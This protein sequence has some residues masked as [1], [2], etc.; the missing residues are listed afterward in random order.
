MKGYYSSSAS[1]SIGSPNLNFRNDCVSPINSPN[2]SILMRYLRSGSPSDHD[3]SPSRN[4]SRPIVS[5]SSISSRSPLSGVE[6]LEEDVL[7]MDG[8]LVD[9]NKISKSA[10]KF[11][12][13][14][15]SDSSPNSG[16]NLYKTELCMSWEDTGT[17]RYG[18]KC[19]FAHGQEEMRPLQNRFRTDYVVQFMDPY[20]SPLSSPFSS[21]SKKISPETTAPAPTKEARKSKSKKASLTQ[22]NDTRS[23]TPN[24][25]STD[26]S[27][28]DDGIV[29][30]LPSS[31]GKAPSRQAVDEHIHSVI[32]GPSQKKRLPVFVDICPE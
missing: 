13:P 16:V 28:M 30:E 25:T 27:P 2:E 18:Y 32:C 21:S 7:V 12:S 23:V 17:C 10:G 20:Y 29:V 1:S 9:S 4:T 8:I 15:N 31:T 22:P 11:R 14:V 3:Y 19:Q 26:W 5:R 6:N 24:L